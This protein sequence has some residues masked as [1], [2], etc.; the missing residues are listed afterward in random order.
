MGL[1]G[2]IMR[3]LEVIVFIGL[4]KEESCDKEKKEKK[5]GYNRETNRSK[6]IRN[7]LENEKLNALAAGKSLYGAF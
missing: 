4:K 3:E 5:S 2:V 7:R 6:I 1:K